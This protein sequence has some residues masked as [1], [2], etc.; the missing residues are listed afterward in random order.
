MWFS[1]ACKS[2]NDGEN[3][4]EGPHWLGLDRSTRR[5]D[6]KDLGSYPAAVGAS[7]KHAVFASNGSIDK[8][9]E[10]IDGRYGGRYTDGFGRSLIGA[11]AIVRD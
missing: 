7:S 6:P 3:Y 4:L 10:R 5:I 8:F 2:L 1:T 9:G 11:Y